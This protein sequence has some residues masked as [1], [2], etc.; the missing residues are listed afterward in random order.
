MTVVAVSHRSVG[1]DEVNPGKLR[2]VGREMKYG[3]PVLFAAFVTGGLRAQP[4]QAHAKPA[5]PVSS[6]SGTASAAASS[7]ATLGA[8]AAPDRAACIQLIKFR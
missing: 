1:N 6:A 2:Q 7:T 3:L 8:T 5:A 4:A